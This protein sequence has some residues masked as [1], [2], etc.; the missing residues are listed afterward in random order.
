MTDTLTNVLVEAVTVI[1]VSK[2]L[3]HYF[4]IVDSKANKVDVTHVLKEGET[5]EEFLKTFIKFFS[6]AKGSHWMFDLETLGLEPESTIVQ[7]GAAAFCPYSSGLFTTLFR[8]LEISLI[9]SA[10]LLVASQE[11]RIDPDTL[12]WWQESNTSNL[13]L[14]TKGDI[15]IVEELKLLSKIWND[16]TELWANSPRF[17]LQ[18]IWDCYR[19]YKDVVPKFPIKFRNEW[20]VRTASKMAN[21]NSETLKQLYPESNRFWGREGN[22]HDAFADTLTQIYQVQAAFRRLKI[23]PVH[24]YKSDK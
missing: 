12:K 8:G 19:Q 6:K 20:D 21:Y 9:H 18:L 11:R 3:S 17:D 14:L 24:L 13:H 4:T 2:P 22:A 5:H 15:T 1:E 10:T 23:G 16:N 7:I